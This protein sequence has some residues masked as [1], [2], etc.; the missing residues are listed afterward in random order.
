[1]PEFEIQILVDLERK[2]KETYKNLFDFYKMPPNIPI[3]VESSLRPL[4]IRVG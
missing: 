2:F 1:V 4:A 3:N